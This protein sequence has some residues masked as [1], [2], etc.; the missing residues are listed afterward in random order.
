[1]KHEERTIRVELTAASIT[2]GLHHDERAIQYRASGTV[3]GE[4]AYKLACLDCKLI[5]RGY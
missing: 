1:M 4:V 5:L 2:D 3:R